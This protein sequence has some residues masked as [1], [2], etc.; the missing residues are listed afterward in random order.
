[1]FGALK[2]LGLPGSAPEDFGFHSMAAMKSQ[3]CIRSFQK[4]P[5]LVQDWLF[6]D[7][8]VKIGPTGGRKSGLGLGLGLAWLGSC[9]LPRLP[10]HT[11]QLL[12]QAYKSS[13]P[14]SSISLTCAL[15]AAFS[16]CACFTMAWNSGSSRR[17][18]KKGSI[19]IKS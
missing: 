1:L 17:L 19:K 16:S 15:I 6:S 9:T 4:L 3:L 13:S 7:Q 5:P 12:S 14:L 8:N 11:V 18:S 2:D 10:V